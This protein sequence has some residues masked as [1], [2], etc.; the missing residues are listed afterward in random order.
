MFFVI[1]LDFHVAKSNKKDG[2]RATSAQLY[3]GRARDQ[4]STNHSAHF[5]EWKSSYITKVHVVWIIDSLL[6]FYNSLHI[7]LQL[8][9]GFPKHHEALYEYLSMI[10]LRLFSSINSSH[11]ILCAILQDFLAKQGHHLLYSIVFRDNSIVLTN[12]I[13]DTKKCLHHKHHHCKVFQTLKE[14]RKSK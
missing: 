14:L 2:V 11:Y 12:Q 8:L 13:S 6:G 9:T 4:E 7:F 3:P 10:E 5:V 1:Y